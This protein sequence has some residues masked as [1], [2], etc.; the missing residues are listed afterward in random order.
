MARACVTPDGA[1]LVLQPGAAHTQ[2]CRNDMGLGA[3]RPGPFAHGPLSCS[4]AGQQAQHAATHLTMHSTSRSNMSWALAWDTDT[5]WGKSMSVS[6][7]GTARVGVGVGLGLGGSQQGMVREGG[8]GGECER[9]ECD[10]GARAPGGAW[11]SRG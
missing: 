2:L 4:R 3:P 10:G 6:C 5:I 1:H 8:K 7:A 11:R 9:E